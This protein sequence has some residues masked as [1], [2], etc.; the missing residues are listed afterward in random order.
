[1]T[2]QPESPVPGGGHSLDLADPAFESPGLGVGGWAYRPSGTSWV[3]GARSGTAHNGSPWFVNP[4][5]SGAQA[6]FVQNTLLEGESGATLSQEITVG[7]PGNYQISFSVVR[8]GNG[9]QGTDLAVRM[10]GVT[11]GVV[12]NG[13]QPDDVWRTFTVPYECSTAGRHVLSF[14]GTRSGGDFASALDDIRILGATPFRVR[15]T[16]SAAGLREAILS[17]ASNDRTRIRSSF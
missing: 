14:V 8:R 9:F 1:M 13:S 5:P 4:A 12:M 2:T 17:I 7:R 16:P 11:L 15:F 3:F 6:A 10:D